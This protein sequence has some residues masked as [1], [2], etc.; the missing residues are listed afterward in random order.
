MRKT[1]LILSS[2]PYGVA[3]IL[4]VLLLT[5]QGMVG[6]LF[7]L[8]GIGIAPVLLIMSVVSVVLA[9]RNTEDRTYDKV[10]KVMSLISLAIFGSLGVLA[11]IRIVIAIT[12]AMTPIPNVIYHG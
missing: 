8:I 12:N 4:L 11:S 2:A 7:V 5:A 9:F 6:L 1:S 10:A 3:L